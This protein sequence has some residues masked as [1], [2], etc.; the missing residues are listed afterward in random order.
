MAS[1]VDTQRA[2][3][4]CAVMEQELREIDRRAG[5]IVRAWRFLD[6]ALHNQPTRLQAVLQDAI[7]DVERTEPQVTEIALGIGLCSRG[8]EGVVAERCTLV[9][10]RSDDCIGIFLS[11]PQGYRRQVLDEPGTVWFTPGWVKHRVAPGPIKLAQ[12][13]EELA[14]RFEPEDVEYLVEMEREALL[15]YSRVCFVDL[16]IGDTDSTRRQAEHAAREM[17]WNYER[18]TGDTTMLHA[19]ISGE[20]RDDWFCVAKPGM[21]FEMSA[22]DDIIRLRSPD[23]PGQNSRGSNA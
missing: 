2:V 20:H 5:S 10:P 1:P 7:D 11:D 21:T 16:T 14:D 9:I 18:I 3:V 4:A 8:T 19:L 22:D 15:A 13:R 17:N 23:H 12:L 6:P